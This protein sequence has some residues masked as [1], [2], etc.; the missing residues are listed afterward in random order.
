MPL[1]SVGYE[2]EHTASGGY[3]IWPDQRTRSTS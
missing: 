2:T 1:G 3:F